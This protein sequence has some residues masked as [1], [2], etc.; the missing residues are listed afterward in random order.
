MA[1]SIPASFDKRPATDTLSST[2]VL[3]LVGFCIAC[4]LLF[5][6]SIVYCLLF[7][8]FVAF[9]VCFVATVVCYAM[10]IAFDDGVV[11]GVC[12]DDSTVVVAFW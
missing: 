9:I 10:A 4:W 8:N 12:V 7:S 5:P 11:V 1:E 3:M 2:D 6:F